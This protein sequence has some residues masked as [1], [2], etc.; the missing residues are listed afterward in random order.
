MPHIK[1]AL[2]RYRIIDRS[3][4]NTFKPYPSKADLRIEC[5][6]QLFGSDGE[7]ICDSTIEKDMSAMKMEH[8]APIKYS[9]RFGGYYYTDEAYSLDEIPLTAK[10]LEAIRFATQTLSQFK[11]T[12]IFK[13]FGNAIEK[14]VDRVTISENPNDKAIQDFVQFETA[15][16][17]GG[18]EYLNPLLD[19]IKEKKAIHFEYA[20]FQ[21]AQKKP[22]KVVPLLL[23]EYRNRW[24]L[25]SHDFV[26]N[27]IITYAL[28]RIENLEVSEEKSN[29][30]PTDFKS[31]LF[32]KHAIGITVG[33]G[34]PEKVVFKVGNVSAKYLLSQP[35]HSSQS[36][37]KEGKNKTTFSLVVYTSEDLIRELLS[38]GAEMEV[39]APEFLRTEMK[40]RIKVM[41]ENYL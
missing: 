24:Y 15:V 23:K 2:I 35:L 28:D 8:D 18:N 31:N 26:K 41:V 27:A 10:D 17:S 34:N 13:D 11:D 20:S 5:E 39:V 29:E 25:I 12:E 4:R 22:R 33:A 7:H 19:A 14:I 32:F 16:Y 3:L 9:K 6:E 30:L 40:R 1:N 37:L 21:T 38:Y 36:L